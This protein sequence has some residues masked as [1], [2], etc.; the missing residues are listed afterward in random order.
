MAKP[1][2]NSKSTVSWAQA[3][4]D[5]IIRAMDRGQLLPVLGFLL[6]LA[7]IWKMPESKVYD[8]GVLILNGFKNLSLAGWVSTVVVCI[9]WAGH[10]RIMRRKHS[11]EYQRI[12]SE[13]S[14]LQKEQV[15][16]PLGSSDNY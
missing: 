1:N 6:V 12:G 8:F 11:S 7:F 9:L 4:R 10:A 5:I 14:R 16:T 3:F 13:K 2:K 15:N